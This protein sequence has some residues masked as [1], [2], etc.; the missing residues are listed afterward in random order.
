[1][2]ST[3]ELFDILLDTFGPQNWWPGDS[4]FEIMIGAIL[5]QNVSWRNVEKAIDNLKRED[6][7]SPD[8]VYK[9][10]LER[11][12]EL[13]KPTGFYRQKAARLKRLSKLILKERGVDSYLQQKDLREQLLDIKG[14]GPETADSIVLYAGEIPTFVVDAYTKRIV[15]RFYGFKGNYEDIKEFF[16]KSLLKD[17]E[18]YNEFHALLV[19]LGKKYCKKTGP[20]C[21]ECPISHLCSY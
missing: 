16:Q 21:G 2:V 8:A 5:T 12:E 9:M 19:E 15:E 4:K 7:L 13:I 10:D 1:M 3:K 17:A 6:A 14:I 18:T 20:R 11:L